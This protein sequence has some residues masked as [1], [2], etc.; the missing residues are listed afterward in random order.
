MKKKRK[1]VSKRHITGAAFIAL[2]FILLM[3]FGLRDARRN[4]QDLDEVHIKV[5]VADCER[6]LSPEQIVDE[7]SLKNVFVDSTEII[8][9][10]SMKANNLIERYK[11]QRLPA[12]VIFGEDL[13]EHFDDL[14]GDAYVD[15]SFVPFFSI[16]EGEVRGIVEAVHI[17]ADECDE[18]QDLTKLETYLLQRGVELDLERLN[19]R[20]EKAKELIE[21]HS[22]RRL[23][24]MILSDDLQFYEIARTWSSFGTK[25]DESFIVR[26]KE[27]IGMPYYD[28][29]E[30]RTVGAVTITYIIDES[31]G[32]CYD[33]KAHKDALRR[34]NLFVSEE[35]TVDVDQ[36][37]GLIDKYSIKSVP[38]MILSPEAGEYDS[39][40]SAW[41]QVGTIEED[42]NLVFRNNEVMQG[43]YRDLQSQK[44]IS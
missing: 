33:I 42:G 3:M 15:Y 22:I 41:S 34:F 23:P 6:C 13:E 10:P 19:M 14:R 1:K 9:Y 24:T 27:A 28:L 17:A 5:I 37:Q 18:C 2:A 30:S 21:K 43:A 7:I 12:V 25:E 44:I 32:A 11:I 36:A 20:S 8:D 40:T 4:P 29:E 35:I 38:T 31:C 26:N 39:L 16:E